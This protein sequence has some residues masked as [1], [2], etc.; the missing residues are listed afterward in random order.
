MTATGGWDSRGDGLTAD[1]YFDSFAI[2]PVAWL[3]IAL[4]GGEEMH[5]KGM[6]DIAAGNG[7]EQPPS[8]GDRFMSMGS[9][10]APVTPPQPLAS[11]TL[12]EVR[13]EIP[14]PLQATAPWTTTYLDEDLRV[15]RSKSGAVFLFSKLPEVLGKG[16]R[17]SDDFGM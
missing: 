3:G 5:R 17:E 4:D 9:A 13:V 11:F 12:P 6:R 14:P 15:G 16:G 7:P 1:V 2:R 10:P 8:S